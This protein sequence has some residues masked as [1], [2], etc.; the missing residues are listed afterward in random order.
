MGH[1]QYANVVIVHYHSA[2]PGRRRVIL[3]VHAHR[4]SGQFRI[5]LGV[6]R[7]CIRFTEQAFQYE[8]R[9][10]CIHNLCLARRLG[11]WCNLSATTGDCRGYM[12]GV[13]H[14][15]L[16]EERYLLVVPVDEDMT[17]RREDVGCTTLREKKK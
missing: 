4:V 7:F 9:A 3:N 14:G 13:Q 12:R 16:R 5:G 6:H 10:E 15:W 8:R 11:A 2:L 17:R 1:A